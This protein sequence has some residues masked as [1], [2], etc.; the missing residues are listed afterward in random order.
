MLN[1]KSLSR[2]S[3]HAD[4]WAEGFVFHLFEGWHLSG[5]FCIPF[6]WRL[7][8]ERKVLYSI[9]LKAD[10]SQTWYRCHGWLPPSLL[11]AWGHW[12]S[13][14]RG[15][16]VRRSRLDASREGASNDGCW[17]QSVPQVC[18]SGCND[19][20]TGSLP[21]GPINSSRRLEA[22]QPQ[23][24]SISLDAPICLAVA[25]T[26]VPLPNIA[27]SSKSFD[28]ATCEAPVWKFS[29]WTIS[30]TKARRIVR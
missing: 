10:M 19:P 5:R 3:F 17:L 4:I 14:V 20:L 23:P 6:V 8:F 12:P 15:H 29:L 2:C 27:R 28:F 7:T 13:T 26:D 21:G 18:D 11:S 16:H 25:D 24:N 9:C 22:M 1:T 30:V